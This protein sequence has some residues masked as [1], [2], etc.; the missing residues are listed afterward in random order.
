MAKSVIP[1]LTSFPE[2]RDPAHPHS[3]RLRGH[4]PDRLLLPAPGLPLPRS[5]RTASHIPQSWSLQG[6]RHCPHT[7]GREAAEMDVPA[8][9]YQE[10]AQGRF[11]L[12]AANEMGGSAVLCYPPCDRSRFCDPGLRRVLLR[13]V[14]VS[15]LRARLDRRHHLHICHHCYVLSPPALHACV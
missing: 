10:E 2:Q 15:G 11:V 7:K 14:V 13:V 5:R 8:R 4:R 1:L 6:Q 12:S 3:G 9:F